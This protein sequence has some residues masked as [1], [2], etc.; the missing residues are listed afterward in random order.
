MKYMGLNPFRIFAFIVLLGV[1]P[2]TAL[3]L[4]PDQIIS[5]TSSDWLISNGIDN[6][7]ISVQ[8]LNTSTPI[9]G[10]S[11]DYSVD[12][13]R[14][15]SL[16]VSHSIT[17]TNGL[18]AVKF[19][20]GTLS[21]NATIHIQVSYLENNQTLVMEKVLIQKIDHGTP[22][23]ISAV[24]YPYE[25]SA[26]S[27]VPFVITLK[28]RY[29]NP[30]D[31]KHTVETLHLVVGSPSGTPADG[32]AAFLSG[33]SYSTDVNI[34]VD[35]NG[36]V[37][38]TLRLATMSGSN[39]IW[40]E[41]I[42]SIP[43]T[44]FT[45]TGIA[46]PIPYRIERTV[47]P[48]TGWQYADGVGTFE[49]DYFVID[50]FGN[51]IR[52]ASILF[53]STGSGESTKTLTSNDLGKVSIIYG[54]KSTIGDYTVTA[55]AV[56]NTSV[57]VTD[58]LTF[59][60][61]E[62]TDM[63]L[64]ASPQ[65]MASRDAD[66]SISSDILAK[67]VDAEG[68]PVEGE[69]VTFQIV[70]STN[71]TYNVTSAPYL[72]ATSAISNSDGYATVHFIPGTFSTNQEDPMYSQTASGSSIISAVWNNV[73]SEVTILWKNY[74]Y[75]SVSTTVS[76]STV[77][78][79]DTVDITILLKGDGFA[80][81]PNPIDVMLVMDESSSMSSDSP[82]RISSAKTAAKTFVDQMNVSRDQIG[83]VS[84]SST[85]SLDQ[86]LTNNFSLVKSKID[87]LSPNGY[88]Q[89][90]NGTYL[91]IKQVNT[92]SIKKT[93]VRA[94]VIMTDGN[95]NY[96]GTPLGHGTGW[97][98]NTSYKLNTSTL[99]IN[100]YRYYDGLGCNLTYYNS[101]YGWG[102]T[103]GET[104]NQNLSL[105]AKNSRIRLY[106]I[107]FAST[108]DSSAVAALQVMASTTGGFY[109]HAPDA[110]GLQEIYKKIAGDLIT[111]AGVN[112]T[113][114]ISFGTV[115]VNNESL[116]GDEV[117]EYVYLDS[118]STKIV[119]PN[120]TITTI[121]QTEN[122][123]KSTNLNFDVG[124]LKLGE[125]WQA[126]I[127]FK[128]LKPGNIDIFGSD[129]RI[130]FNNGTDTLALPR[131]Y[132]TAIPGLNNSGVNFVGL[133]ISDLAAT[134]ST[135][136]QLAVSWDFN[137]TG[138]QVATEKV[139]YSTDEGQ[140]WKTLVVLT[141]SSGQYSENTNLDLNQIPKTTTVY[142]RVDGSGMDGGWDRKET[143]VNTG[144]QDNPYIR[145]E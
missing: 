26:G 109:S 39:M 18:S 77:A 52:N 37:S 139:F 6:S 112:T 51:G 91:G 9:S 2:A 82:S 87:L 66:P 144:Y 85:S 54:P 86:G 111:E 63:I 76:P 23:Q 121:N 70:S 28:D 74:P 135:P 10:I 5:S 24:Q 84:F 141:R 128:V 16:N 102:C 78:V 11:V 92:T 120:G 32:L 103:D 64:T 94:V 22:Y 80:L 125:T 127:R 43:A 12:D 67:V 42:G 68:N 137:Y 8:I 14:Y 17:D 38:T 71:G 118:V 13:F 117:F 34:P 27:S 131:T 73:T 132:V 7:T 79:N 75:L 20:A 65:T 122:W 145:L 25:A 72:D 96:D 130:I 90:R 81:Q 62:A 113:M 60:S 30:I 126:T 58:V 107:S 124:T 83:L 105:Y 50:K 57:S 108:L 19:Q 21:G 129:S 29:G 114:N 99:D 33:T 123:T 55:T 119:Q 88:T 142:I 44:Y 41:G 136:T 133:S 104:S 95:W 138:T 15:G 1:I 56:A 36:N 93:A 53:S 116:P 49:I 46:D 47:T 45:I 98:L 110:S 61:T 3:A 48:G 69:T 31:N 89:L 140:S 40:M 134:Q 106:T 35:A 97:P 115:S 4:I 100:N 59:I 143:S 101:K